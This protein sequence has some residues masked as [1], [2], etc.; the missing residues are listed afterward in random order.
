M[1]RTVP[2]NASSFVVGQQ[3]RESTQGNF[4]GHARKIPGDENR[5]F[6]QGTRVITIDRED[7]VTDRFYFCSQPECLRRIPGVGDSPQEVA[8]TRRSGDRPLALR[9]L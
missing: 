1:L 9:I 4:E 5:S 7:A 2:Q 3:G 6:F 8:G